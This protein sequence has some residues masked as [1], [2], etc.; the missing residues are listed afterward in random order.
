[1]VL[2]LLAFTVPFRVAPVGDIPVAALVVAVGGS[3][4][5]VKVISA[6][7]VVP[8]ILVATTCRGRLGKYVFT[9]YDDIGGRL[10][11]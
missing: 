4:P 11:R 5:V 7:F 6:P 3:D 8:L 1:M 9:V 10:F 2:S